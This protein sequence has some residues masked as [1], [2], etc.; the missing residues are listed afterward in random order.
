MKLIRKVPFLTEEAHR[1]LGA[2]EE[3]RLLGTLNTKHYSARGGGKEGFGRRD[4]RNRREM[5]N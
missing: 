4:R 3:P 5:E 2:M 1:R